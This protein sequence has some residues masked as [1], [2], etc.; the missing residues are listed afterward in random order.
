[1]DDPFEICWSCGT[2]RDGVEDPGFHPEADGVMTGEDFEQARQARAAEPLVT[3]A[4]FNSGPEA[5][6]ARNHLEAEG[7]PALVV[8]ED[9]VLVD[10]LIR[11]TLGGIKLQVFEKDVE[12]ARRIL[13]DAAGRAALRDDEEDEGDEDDQ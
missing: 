13:A 8:G 10:W 5:R 12:Q 9:S 3:I 7:I 4:M 1:V 2:S 6:V 11:D